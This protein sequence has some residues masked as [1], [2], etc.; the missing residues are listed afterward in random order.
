MRTY[1]AVI[2]L[3]ACRGSDPAPEPPVPP[4]ATALAAP[5]VPRAQR[6]PSIK[7][8]PPGAVPAGTT[9]FYA[10]TFARQPSVPEL[11]ALG[12][13]VFRDRSLSASGKLACASCHDPDRAFGP[14]NARAVQL[15]GPALAAAGVRAT[16][17][18]RYLQ[19]VPR[20]TEHF[21]DG[22]DRDDADQGPAG[23]LTWD[24]RAQSTHDQARS[25][26]FSP[27]EMALASPEELLARLRRAGYADRMRA[28][29]GDGVLDRA[30]SALKAATLALEVYQ[31]DPAAFYPYTSKYDAVLRGQESLTAQEERGRKLFDDPA[32]GNC[33]SCHPDTVV[34]GL[35]AFTDFGYNAIAAPR[36]REIPK[37]ADPSYFDLGLC[38]PYRTDLAGH[39]EYCGM[40]RT[41]SLRNVALRRRFMHNG[42]FGSLDQVLAFYATRDTEP[43]RWYP[44][45]VP[46]DLPARYRGNISREAP[47]GG[48]PGDPPRLSRAEIADVIAF[49]GTLT[50]R[51]PK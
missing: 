39:G 47:F 11:A 34:D 13:L 20:F 50:D 24:G 42:V 5:T 22:D 16:P 32:K 46:D 1:L 44:G 14:P 38:G 26:L 48:A 28:A 19:T 43:A 23:G 12:A 41:P 18:L 40:F 29:F 51:S 9:A 36:N 27:L 3:V 31:Q 7:R 2:A 30:D 21:H 6:R 25:P 49:L 4:P 33:A 37:N 45:G 8:A 15:G 35:P 17:S 10:S